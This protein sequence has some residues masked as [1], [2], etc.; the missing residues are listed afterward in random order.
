MRLQTEQDGHKVTTERLNP[1]SYV[2]LGALESM[3]PATPYELKRRIGE[4]IA[5][6][7]SFSHAQFYEEPPRLAEMGLLT[8]E[9][10]TFGRR[11]RVFAI[12]DA[13]RAALRS[14]FDEPTTSR[15][16][17]RDLGIVKLFF[18]DHAEPEQIEELVRQQTQVHT[19]ILDEYTALHD[20]YGDRE[21]IGNRPVTIEMGILF[22]RAM[23]DFWRSLRVGDDG[24][25]HRVATEP[26][27]P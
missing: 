27:S 26:S 14:W 19:E 11:R 18:S 1:I 9:Q 16:E 8:E 20:R 17:I 10:E 25:V 22:E 21:D 12:T 13:G 23:V 5:F 4:T 7:W 2:L 6:F 24:R 15:R 3:G